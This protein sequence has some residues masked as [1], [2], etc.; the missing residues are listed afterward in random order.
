MTEWK[1]FVGEEHTF[2]GIYYDYYEDFEKHWKA[3]STQ[4][5]NYLRYCNQIIPLLRN[6]D[7][8][9]I[10]AYT[11]DDYDAVIQTLIKRGQDTKSKQ[12]LRL[13][14]LTLCNPDKTWDYS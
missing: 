10:S 14:F 2:Y 9:P 8:T 11:Q 7:E 6:H 4:R 13:S 12:L 5:S 3:D 1:C